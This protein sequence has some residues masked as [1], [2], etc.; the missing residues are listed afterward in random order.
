M[1]EDGI[2]SSSL[3]SKGSHGGLDCFFKRLIVTFKQRRVNAGFRSVVIVE[4]RARGDDV[5]NKVDDDGLKVKSSGRDECGCFREAAKFNAMFLS[6]IEQ[7]S[8]S[9]E[10]WLS[11]SASEKQVREA[12][13]FQ[14][15]RYVLLFPEQWNQSLELL[16]LH[17]L[18]LKHPV[19]KY[20]FNTI[21]RKKKIRL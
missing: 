15:L 3:K 2:V 10:S 4:S 21:R 19:T 12:S 7:G 5:Q 18:N 8:F 11:M 17:F 6:N 13:D 9:G 1:T 20:T 16:L 14:G